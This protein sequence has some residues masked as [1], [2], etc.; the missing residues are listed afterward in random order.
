VHC[1]GRLLLSAQPNLW[2][3]EPVL[4]R[5]YN[6]RLWKYGT[7]ATPWDER[8]PDHSRVVIDGTAFVHW[9]DCLTG[10]ACGVE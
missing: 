5:R 3:S 2:R 10:L 6:G 9:Y 7:D 4:C 8:F 1:T